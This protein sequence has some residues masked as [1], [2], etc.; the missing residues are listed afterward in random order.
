[1]YLYYPVISTKT[2]GEEPERWLEE[3]KYDRWSLENISDEQKLWIKRF[4]KIKDIRILAYC[5]I[6]APELIRKYG[7]QRLWE[8]FI[9]S[10]KIDDLPEKYRNL[11]KKKP[12]ESDPPDFSGK[13]CL[14]LDCDGVLWKGILGE[15]GREEIKITEAFKQLQQKALLL[16]NKGILLA[17]NRK[18]DK[19]VLLGALRAK[20]EDFRWRVDEMILKDFDFAVIE[21]NWKD[22][23]S[24]MRA[25]AKK[26]NI[27]LDSFVFLDDSLH[28]REIVRMNCPEVLI[29]EK[30]DSAIARM[31]IL[32]DWLQ[33]ESLTGVTEV[34]KKRTELYQQDEQ[35][36]KDKEAFEY[37]PEYYASLE[38][39][40]GIREGADNIPHIDR[41]AQLISRTH[42]FN[43]SNRVWSEKGIKK[44]IR[45]D[46]FRVFSLELI[47]KFGNSGIVAVMILKKEY[48]PE[49]DKKYIWAINTLCMSCRAIG[50]TV[51]DVFLAQVLLALGQDEGNMLRAYY[52]ETTKNNKLI[53]AFLEKVGFVF[54]QN[55][56]PDE[57]LKDR[58]YLSIIMPKKKTIQQWELVAR[59]NNLQGPEWITI[60]QSINM[61][62]QIKA[63][64]ENNRYLESVNKKISLQIIEKAI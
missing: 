49:D 2:S 33:S 52:D 62:E 13:K 39:K 60:L 15:V 28:E 17:I 12:T 56:S 20:K 8:D 46:D 40:A 58:E 35:R 11:D 37:L 59:K 41:I 54:K 61:E 36:K 3:R 18:N 23:V 50:M 48:D 5:V 42:Q 27:G 22:K 19:S 55:V 30:G 4:E 34:D 38:M 63:L 32:D 64:L 14:V 24:N 45:D 29:P 31:A 1:M 44:I 10:L 21:A 51:E 53:R 6:H 25:I 43:L 7:N 16:K 26:L 47:D 9:S 57:K